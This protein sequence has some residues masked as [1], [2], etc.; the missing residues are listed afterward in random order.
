MSALRSI[1]AILAVAC[2][3]LLAPAAGEA[4][5][6][7]SP[8]VDE[9]NQ[10]R[11]AHGVRPVLYS[12]SLS[13]SS[14]RFARYLAR[15]RQFGHSSPI[16]ASGRFS[17]LGEILALVR[18]PKIQRRQTLSAW[19]YSPS[20]REVVLNPAYRYAG[21]GR[22]RGSFEGSSAVVWTVHFGR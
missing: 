21:A 8:M 3:F 15:T 12:P 18:G 4:R 16:W 1:A 13:R 17:R 9:I 7:P 14:S 11:K 10:V 19:L 22:A 6:S 2:T 20:H 5:E